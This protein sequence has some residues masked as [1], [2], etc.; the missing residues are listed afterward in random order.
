MKTAI[1]IITASMMFSLGC[2][3][4]HHPS[5][6]ELKSENEQLESQLAATREKIDEAKSN[7]DE[8]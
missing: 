4:S 7:L 1:A 3:T 6:E 5:Y 2:E 8:T